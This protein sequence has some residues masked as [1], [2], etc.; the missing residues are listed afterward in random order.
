MMEGTTHAKQDSAQPLADR[1]RDSLAVGLRH[2]K[3]VAL[4]FLGVL[5]GAILAALLLPPHYQAQ[6]KILVK[7]ERVDPVVTADP[8]GASVQTPSAVTEVELNSEVEFIKGPELLEKVVLA[9]GLQDPEDQSSWRS[10]F[11]RSHA[12][13]P[14]Q[15]ATS[16][17]VRRLEKAL[18]VETLPKTSLISVTYESTSPQKAAQVLTTLVNLYFEKHLAVHRPAGTFEFF[19]QQTKEYE[20]GLAN[21]ESRLLGFSQ[22]QGVVS[23]QQEKDSALRKVSEFDTILKQTQAAIAETGRRIHTLE[24]QAASTPSR[25]TTQVR[26]ADNP[27][28][29]GQLKS[30]LLNLELKRTELLGKFLPSYYLV[31]EVDT[32]IAQTRAAIE[33]AEKSQ[34]REETTDRD[35]TYEWA[36][37]ELAKARAELDALRAREA[38]TSRNLHSYQEE[39]RKLDEKEII[40]QSLLRDVK[41]EETNYLLY[42]RKQEE[43]RISDALD[44]SRIV[45]VAVA[46]PAAVPSVPIR[47]RGLVVL[48][49]FL[50]A[51]AVSIAAAIAAEY[52]DPALRTRHEVEEFLDVPVLASVSE[53]GR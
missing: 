24:G 32:Q 37:E 26:T 48:L 45:N 10:V 9:C 4:S 43:A 38:A 47:S 44:R 20:Q 15:K 46:E 28:L 19:R 8:S 13:N 27:Q 33:S 25:L 1:L 3:L 50:L 52:L 36:R 35:P 39:A 31:Q 17:A 53:N 12:A 2:R 42:L 18:K 11:D 29:M 16:A 40:Q 7:H 49:G 51:C 5:L 23:P 41:A 14:S 6:T 22:Q 34:L 30:T 21:A